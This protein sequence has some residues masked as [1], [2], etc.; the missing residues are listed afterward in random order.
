MFTAGL[1]DGDDFVD[2]LPKHQKA[3]ISGTCIDNSENS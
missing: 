3:P 1:S 2:A